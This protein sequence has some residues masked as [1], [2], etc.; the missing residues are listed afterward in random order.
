MTIRQEAY[1]LIDNLP[2]DSVK[3]VIQIM[4][5]MAPASDKTEKKADCQSVSLKMQAFLRMQ[6]LRKKM[7]AYDLSTDQ[8]DIY[9]K[10][11]YG[12]FAWAGGTE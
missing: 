5:R 9:L 11:K 6:E 2:D 12:S 1:N 3:A 7:P 4:I 8:K 10:E